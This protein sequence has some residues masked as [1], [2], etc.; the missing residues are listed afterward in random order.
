MKQADRRWGAENARKIR[1]RLEDLAAFACLADVPGWPPFRC[2]PLK[3]Q[4]QGQYAVDVKHPFR[5]V[6]EPDHDPLPRLEDGGLDLRR[7]TA[8]QVLSVEDYHGD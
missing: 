4:R 3:G 1:Q 5:L 2:H 8:I 6:F 7:V